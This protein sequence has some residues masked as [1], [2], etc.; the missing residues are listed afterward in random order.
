MSIYVGA[1]TSNSLYTPTKPNQ[2]ASSSS[3]STTIAEA[4]ATIA[5]PKVEKPIPKTD[6]PKLSIDQ[7]AR[8]RFANMSFTP[9][10]I[11]GVCE[12]DPLKFTGL[13]V[14]SENQPLL[15]AIN[16]RLDE[17]GHNAMT[18]ERFDLNHKT[19][20]LLQIGWQPMSMK[21]LD[22]ELQVDYATSDLISMNVD[23]LSDGTPGSD[24]DYANPS[25]I[26][27][28]TDIAH[29]QLANSESTLGYKVNLRELG[30]YNGLSD[31]QIHGKVVE[32]SKTYSGLEL[33]KAFNEAM[34]NKMPTPPASPPANTLLGNSITPEAY[35]ADKLVAKLDK[36]MAAKAEKAAETSGKDASH[37]QLVSNIMD[38]K[39]I[40][41]KISLMQDQMIAEITKKA[42]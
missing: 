1:N 26:K 15:E 19:F 7:E 8:Q 40:A 35:D 32:L 13:P 9:N 4:T 6:L 39:A 24:A 2:P 22:H 33:I 17:I 3:F 16:K 30:Q 29:Q 12:Y 28:M 27:K 18:Q 42:A 5:T 25:Y 11:A 20:L 36:K 23:S 21:E 38:Q 14:C 10:P 31:D 41:Q 37:Q 34:P